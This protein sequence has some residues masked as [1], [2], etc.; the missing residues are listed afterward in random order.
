[1]EEK[2]KKKKKKEAAAAV[3]AMTHHYSSEC[4]RVMTSHINNHRTWMTRLGLA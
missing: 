2:K 3:A 4:S 1:L